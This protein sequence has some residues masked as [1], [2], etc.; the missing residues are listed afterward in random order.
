MYNKVGV[1]GDGDV[2]LAF[3]SIGFDV[4][5]ATA[6]EEVRELY[7]TLSKENY[8]VLY[9]TEEL[10]VE[11]PDI[12]KKAKSKEYPIITPLPTGKN[13]GVGM[14]G[15][16]KDVEKAIGVDILFNK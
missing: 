7:K 9:I 1:I 4:F 8:A 15:I 10:A 3:K 16:K 5:N 13:L 11:V 12:L 6:A 14:L 2:V